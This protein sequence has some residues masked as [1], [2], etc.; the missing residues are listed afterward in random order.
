MRFTWK[1]CNSTTVTFYDGLCPLIKYNRLFIEV[2]FEAQQHEEKYDVKNF[3]LF[4]GNHHLLDDNGVSRETR[5]RCMPQ[6]FPEPE[7]TIALEGI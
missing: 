2:S 5:I 6:V 4:I 7:D 1:K 3:D